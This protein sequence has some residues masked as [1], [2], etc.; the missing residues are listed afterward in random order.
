M[1]RSP[2]RA[3]TRSAGS[4]SLGRLLSRREP[5]DVGDHERRPRGPQD[6]RHLAH[7]GAGAEPDGDRTAAFDGDQQNVDRR[8]VLVPDRHPVTGC[9]A[10]REQSVGEVGGGVVELGPGERAVRRV[11][12]EVDVGRLVRCRRGIAHDAFG[13]GGIRPPAGGSVLRCFGTG[14]GGSFDAHQEII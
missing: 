4:A 9:Y 1:T 12:G 11:E 8:G 10:Q 7:S 3:T 2:P 14:D 6:C 5:V 13:Q